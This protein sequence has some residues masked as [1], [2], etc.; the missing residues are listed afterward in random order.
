MLTGSYNH[1]NGFSNNVNTKFD[2]SQLTFPKHLQKVGYQMAM[3][4]KWHLETVPT[5]CDF[6]QTLPRQGLTCY[7]PRPRTG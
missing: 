3:I 2:G 5:G 7:P 4:G 6:W 1:I